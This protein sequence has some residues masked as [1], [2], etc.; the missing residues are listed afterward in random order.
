MRALEVTGVKSAGKGM[1]GNTGRA[2]SG[3]VLGA[4]AGMNANELKERYDAGDRSPELIKALIGVIGP[5][6]ALIPAMGPKTARIKGAGTIASGAVMG[7]DLYKM[8]QKANEQANAEEK[9]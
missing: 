4:Y 5:S 2:I 1:M 6:T 3:G 9:Q 7:Y 8:I